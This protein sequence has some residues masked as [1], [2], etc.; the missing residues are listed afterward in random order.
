MKEL[1]IER[2]IEHHP[3]A[4]KGHGLLSMELVERFMPNVTVDLGVDYG[5]STFCLAYHGIGKVFGI[6]WFKGDIHTGFRDTY[7]DVLNL[8][9]KI[10]EEFGV[11]NAYFIKSDFNDAASVWDMP[12]DLLHI[13]GL[14]TYEAVK[15]DYL[16]WKGFCNEESVI[17]FHDV[18]SF[19]D[20]VGRFFWECEGYKSI[21]HGSAGLGVLTRS[22]EKHEIIETLIN[23]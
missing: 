18:E 9:K 23:K 7:D 11:S 5:F 8:Y 6:D 14:H 2:L 15:N 4:W 19:S 3:T 16:T 13:D 17:L 12:I 10:N 20:T 22:R 1:Y 21:N